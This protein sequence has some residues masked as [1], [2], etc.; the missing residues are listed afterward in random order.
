MWYHSDEA[1][2]KTEFQCAVKNKYRIWQIFFQ[3]IINSEKIP[4]FQN[5]HQK[6]GA[7]IIVHDAIMQNH[8]TPQFLQSYCWHE[9]QN[10]S[11][12]SEVYFEKQVWQVN[13][14]SSQQWR[15]ICRSHRHCEATKNVGIQSL[16]HTHMQ[17][18]ISIHNRV[19]LQSPKTFCSCLL[20]ALSFWCWKCT[21]T[22]MGSLNRAKLLK[23]HLNIGKK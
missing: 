4:E 14:F 11:L 2:I 5:K 21:C 16:G 10:H 13:I 1:P 20:L 8:A 12:K 22:A 17:T 9:D 15:F 7:P 19:G 18:S 23:M 6:H 3:Q